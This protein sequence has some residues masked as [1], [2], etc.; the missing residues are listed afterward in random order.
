MLP[1]LLIVAP[2]GTGKTTLI[3]QL[4]VG[5]IQRGYRVG[6]FK[7]GHHA[8]DM[9]R[10]GK[11]TY[12]YRQAGAT[13]IGYMTQDQWFYFR[14]QETEVDVLAEMV[15]LSAGHDLILVEGYKSLPFPKILVHRTAVDF[16]PEPYNMEN[17]I[18][19]V[20]DDPNFLVD[21]ICPRFAFQDVESIVQCITDWIQKLGNMVSGG[22]PSPSD[23]HNCLETPKWPR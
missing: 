4:L 23:P 21:L 5:L 14:H 16:E 22:V 17:V 10:V 8:P 6:V 1:V 13:A 9:D 18:A 2:S 12:R 7:H 3:E 19:I 15:R 20:A 11:D